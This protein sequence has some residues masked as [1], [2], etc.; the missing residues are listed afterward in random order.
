MAATQSKHLRGVT[1]GGVQTQPETSGGSAL[2]GR[3]EGALT[4]KAVE[5]A[6]PILEPY[7]VPVGAGRAFSPGRNFGRRVRVMS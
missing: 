1:G 5:K 4:G 2:R 7:G 6:A 3:G